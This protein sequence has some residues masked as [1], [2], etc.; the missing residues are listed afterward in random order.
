MRS[1]YLI[2][3]MSTCNISSIRYNIK[4]QKIVIIVSY[5]NTWQSVNPS[6]VLYNDVQYEPTCKIMVLSLVLVQSPH[7]NAANDTTH[8]CKLKTYIMQTRT[9]ENTH[10]FLSDQKTTTTKL[11]SSQEKRPKTKPVKFGGTFSV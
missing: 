1:Y 5:K 8:N 11:L 6:R 3:L 2:R 7:L 10:M 4:V 9:A